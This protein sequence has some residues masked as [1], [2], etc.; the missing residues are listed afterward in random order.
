MPLARYRKAAWIAG[1]VVA[2]VL[3]IYAAVGYLLAPSLVRRA[4][5]ERAA[6]AGLDLRVGAISTDPFLLVVEGRDVR[7][8]SQKGQEI[9][10]AQDARVDLS[11]ASLWRRDWVI[12][13]VTL[14][15][16][17]LSVQ[18]TPRLD[19]LQLDGA[20]ER[21]RASAAMGSGRVATTGSFSLAPAGA[22]GELEL[23]AVPLALAWRYLPESFGKAPAG[24]IDGKARFRYAQGRLT[25]SQPS[26]Q[27][28]LDSGG[29]LALVGDIALAPFKADLRLEADAVPVALAQPLLRGQGFRL[30]GGA[31][32]GKGRL[33]LGERPS[34]AGTASLSGVRVEDSDGA[35]L[36]GWQ[37]LA[38][39]SLRI[40]FSPFALSA[41]DVLARA[42]HVNAIIAPDGSLN[43]ARAF[44]KG[45]GG[46]P[47]ERPDISL[48]QLRIE[49]GRLDFADRSLDTPFATTAEQLSGSLTRLATRGEEPARLALEGRVGRYGEARIRGI[50]DLEAPASRTSVSLRFRN[51]ALADFTP[52]AAKFA[53]YRIRAGRLDAELSYR[54]REGRLVGDNRLAFRRLRLGD[55]VDSPSALDLP[56][57]L[58]VALLTDAD[59]R[60]DL[61]IPVSGDL[62][63]PRV[64]LGGLIAK[65][66]RNTVAKIVSAPFRMLASL[67]GGGNG[68]RL[69][70]VRF[71]PGSAKLSPPAEETLARLARAL[72]RRPGLSLEIHG[73]YDERADREALQR[74][75][76]LREL[77]V[78][79]G[80]RKF[81]PVAERLYL[82]RG[83][84]SADL[85]ALKPR[86]RGYARRLLDTLASGTGVAPDALSGL[87]GARA[88]AIREALQR[89][90]V[91]SARVA[92]AAPLAA[93]ADEDGVP[94]SL[95][96][97]SR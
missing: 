43:L 19:H 34:Y 5:I 44:S 80:E 73:A 6:A 84:R 7:L 30:A 91:D 3:A 82:A 1:A 38:T 54:V 72:A 13:R 69:R 83:G 87:A 16:G 97:Q 62:R 46:A 20:G 12:D 24:R 75:Q 17:T 92:L 81:V 9:G 66:V 85:S 68:E 49:E 27:A 40:A 53:G 18:G 26:A 2:T 32:S 23:A 48:G 88:Q 35:P 76:L 55:K 8:S 52:Y 42:P 50:V 71:E 15:E 58:A 89:A 41:D 14:S 28:R 21:F 37:S 90:G 77:G 70:E 57:E 25:L 74:A 65:A 31:L 22:A 78:E 79:A 67:F 4:L 51:L 96:L 94:A 11:W 64:D 95:G 47:G 56:L 39:E 93:Q 10:S 59:G 33:Q 45:E 86:E 36:V 60:L 61:A 29:R 63:D